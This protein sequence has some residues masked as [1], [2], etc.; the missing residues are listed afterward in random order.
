MAQEQEYPRPRR[1]ILSIVRDSI[2][3]IVAAHVLTFMAAILMRIC[4]G[5]CQVKEDLFMSP[6]FKM[7]MERVWYIQFGGQGVSDLLTYYVMAK[8]AAKFSDSL[9]IVCVVFFGYHIVD[10]FMFWYDFNGHFYIYL[11]LIWTALILVKY[12]VHPYKP[13]RLARI[14][15]LF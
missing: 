11:D 15:A 2:I 4:P 3:L 10:V 7:K 14:K 12:A 6:W 8:I 9:F 1:P 5:W 13:E